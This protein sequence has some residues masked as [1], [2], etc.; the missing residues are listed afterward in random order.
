MSGLRHAH[1][2]GHPLNV[3]QSAHLTFLDSRL[4]GND[5]SIAR[6]SLDGYNYNR[7]SISRIMAMW[8]S[9]SDKAGKRS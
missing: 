3:Y 6:P 8:M 9:S 4:H 7:Q 1:F 2:H 5:R